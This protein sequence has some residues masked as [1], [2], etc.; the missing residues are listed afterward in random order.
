MRLI[1]GLMLSL[2]SFTAIA[3][4]VVRYYKAG[5]IISIDGYLFNTEAQNANQLQLL[6]G[7]HYKDLFT[8]DESIIAAQKKQQADLQAQEQLWQDQSKTLSDRLVE[9]NDRS[10]L[11][12]I[13]WFGLGAGLT[14]ALAFGVNKATK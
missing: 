3:D 6:E 4:P 8:L 7:D 13:L 10:W 1:A 5:S 9:S 2:V 11:K 14:T 12:D